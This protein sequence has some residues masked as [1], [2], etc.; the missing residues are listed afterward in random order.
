M[1][2]QAIP[3]DL[4]LIQTSSENGFCCYVETKSLDGETNLKEK[5]IPSELKDVKLAELGNAYVI[6]DLPSDKIYSFNGTITSSS[7]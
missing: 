5:S 2:D 3:A 6:A 7:Q 1:K 4:I